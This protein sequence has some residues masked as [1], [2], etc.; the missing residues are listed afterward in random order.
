MG[1]ETRETNG[2]ATVTRFSEV[3][4]GLDFDADGSENVFSLDSAGKDR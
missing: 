4:S 1:M 3:E 2:D